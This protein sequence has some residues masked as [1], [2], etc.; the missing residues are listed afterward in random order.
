MLG[1]KKNSKNLIIRLVRRWQKEKT[2]KEILSLLQ[3]EFPPED[4]KNF[5]LYN[6]HLVYGEK[7]RTELGAYYTPDN[8]VELGKR[9]LEAL[10]GSLED[11]VILDPAA[12]VGLFCSK[13]GTPK[14]L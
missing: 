12:G 14:K 11:Y 6:W 4:V 9:E 3:K 8:I 7:K 2:P 13:T 10:L 1:L 5:L